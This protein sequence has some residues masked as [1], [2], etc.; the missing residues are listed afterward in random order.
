MIGTRPY[1]GSQV[2]IGRH[3]RKRLRRTHREAAKGRVAQDLCLDAPPE[4]RPQRAVGL[5]LAGRAETT[6]LEAGKEP[7]Y[8]ERRHVRAGLEEPLKPPPIGA[9]GIRRAAGKLLREQEGLDRACE[10]VSRGFFCG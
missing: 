5:M 3:T 8:G 2:V 7:P 4:K 6:L 9:Q 10:G 1:Q